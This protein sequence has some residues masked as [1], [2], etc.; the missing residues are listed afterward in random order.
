MSGSGP[1][2]H[3]FV[4]A[5]GIRLHVVQAGPL[6]GPLVLLLHGFPEF[7]FGWRYQ[8]PALAKAGYRV[9]APDLR[10]YNLSEKPRGLQAYGLRTL[11]RDVVG[12]I[13]AAG[14]ETAD[15]VG[16]DW[17]GAV[18][19]RLATEH[20]AR[21]RRL[22]VLNCPLPG[23]MRR[24]LATSPAQMLRSSYIFFF[25]LP[26]LP[27]AAIR[28]ADSRFLARSLRLT[29][30]SGTFSEDDLERYRE[31]WRQPGA[32]SAMI[33]WYRAAL[34]GS[35]GSGR[36]ADR[37]R[38][39]TLILWGARDRFLPLELAEQSLERCENGR[40]EIVEEATHWIQHE[41]ADRV[42]RSLIAFLS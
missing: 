3:H 42:N 11:A 28:F 41:E 29:S 19:W 23:V 35:G 40:L 33:N 9:W 31:A 10:G 12:L 16:H 25:Q 2:E 20:R 34:R 24:K 26:L 39:P 21:V 6:D 17:G 15:V 36:G 27:E 5:N 4:E 1:L 13:D 7:W 38:T 18:G 22:A 30:R 14:R 32:A 37:I 8:I